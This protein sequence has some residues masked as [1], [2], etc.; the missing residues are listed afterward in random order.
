MEQRNTIMYEIE[1]RV[2]WI[3]LNR[4]DR[5]NALTSEMNAELRDV[6]S[7]ASSDARVR[8][9]VLTGAGRGFC[10]GADMQNLA[11]K[12]PLSNEFGDSE[13][14]ESRL[15]SDFGPSIDEHLQNAQQFGYFLRVKKP[16]IAAVNGPAVGIGMVLTL[17]ADVRLASDSAMFLT[18]FARRGLVAEHG[19][20]WILP[21]Y[22]GFPAALEMSLSSRKISA[23]E[24]RRLQL[25]SRVI[26]AA[27]FRQEVQ[28]YARDLAE[29][30][31]PRS[32]AV[33]KAQFW[34]AQFQN[35]DEAIAT[36][37]REVRLCVTHDDF[38]EGVAHFQE[39]RPPVFQDI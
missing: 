34:K 23:E 25:V 28:D 5:L 29:N 1:D 12:V 11:N 17:Y 39:R 4:P 8:A 37:L 22:V 19:V 10:A 24:A 38:K 21:K 27:T 15:R 33:I 9:I 14:F 35:L 30:V 13:I 26:P 7:M 2:A 32:M 36:A 16:V 3:T 31:S 20:S 6:V 18:G